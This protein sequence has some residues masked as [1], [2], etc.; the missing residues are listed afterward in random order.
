MEAGLLHTGKQ[1]DKEANV[2]G[3]QLDQADGF[4]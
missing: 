3:I 1:E 4:S 2:D